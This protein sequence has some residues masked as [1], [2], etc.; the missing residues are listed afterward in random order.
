MNPLSNLFVERNVPLLSCSELFLFLNLKLGVV[1][2]GYCVKPLDR[3]LP[4]QERA[5][6]KRE[7][8]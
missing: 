6:L 2:L 3:R 8:S 1:S 4:L 5:I 7:A